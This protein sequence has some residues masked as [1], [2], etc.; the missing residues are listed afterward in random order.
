MDGYAK[1]GRANIRFWDPLL[2]FR[3]SSSQILPSNGTTLGPCPTTIAGAC[4][5]LEPSRI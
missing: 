5:W 1:V 4:S 3:I 2:K